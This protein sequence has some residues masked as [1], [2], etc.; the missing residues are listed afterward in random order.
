[1]RCS[2]LERGLLEGSPQVYCH[3]W[4]ERGHLEQD[5]TCAQ[6]LPG[7]LGQNERCTTVW[8]VLLEDLE[9]Y[10]LMMMPGACVQETFL[11]KRIY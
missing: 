2:L 9:L 10:E 6:N 7:L 4:V 8:F 3:L 5:E 11:I 1:M